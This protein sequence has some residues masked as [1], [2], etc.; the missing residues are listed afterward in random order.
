MNIKK[1]AFAILA[2][3]IS[4]LILGCSTTKENKTLA[5]SEIPPGHAKIVGVV[6]EIEPVS[7]SSI[8][9]DPCSK[10]PCIALVKVTSAVYGA[11]FPSFKKDEEVRIKFLFTLEKTNK[12]LFP[13]MKEEYPGLEIGQKFSALIAY[14][15]SINEATPKFNVYGYDT[16]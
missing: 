2:F 7:D 5:K 9:N 11:A 16:D 14:V 1:P 3:I 12:E 10:A 4:A 8:L 6:T 13:D 15:E